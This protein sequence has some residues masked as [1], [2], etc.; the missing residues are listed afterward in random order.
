ML[1]LVIA[2]YAIGILLA[3][4]ASN[5]R[6]GGALSLVAAAV[7]VVWV[8]RGGVEGMLEV[9]VDEVKAVDDMKKLEGKS[10]EVK[11]ERLKAIIEV[12]E[13]LEEDDAK[14]Y[15]EH[16][17]R[18]IPKESFASGPLSVCPGRAAEFL[19]YQAARE[20]SV[21]GRPSSQFA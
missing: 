12:K 8:V 21:R 20:E 4:G 15:F 14:D 3:L 18:S 13:V 16:A 7:Y 19:G 6:T 11:A 5:P 17:V 9:H 2:G 10:E 1:V